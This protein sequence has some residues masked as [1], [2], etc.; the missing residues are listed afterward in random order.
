MDECTCTPDL[1]Y[2]TVTVTNHCLK[3][4]LP[5]KHILTLSMNYCCV[6]KKTTDLSRR[7]EL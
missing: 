2:S 5:S 1:R 3:T 6:Q 4:R 7:S